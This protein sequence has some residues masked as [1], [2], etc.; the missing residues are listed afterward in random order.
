MS[1]INNRFNFFPIVVNLQFI[2]AYFP[3]SKVFGFCESE[4]FSFNPHWD[5]KDVE[6]EFSVTFCHVNG[7]VGFDPNSPFSL[8]SSPCRRSL[9]PQW[10]RLHRESVRVRFLQVMV[11][12]L[13]QSLWNRHAN[14]D[15]TSNVFGRRV[16]GTDSYCC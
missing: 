1:V 14:L 13:L 5:L 10:F 16:K 4:C 12:R 9:H 11:L 6:D 7:S 8:C 2:S 15:R 3:V